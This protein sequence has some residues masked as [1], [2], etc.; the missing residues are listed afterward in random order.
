MLSF[1]NHLINQC[2]IHTTTIDEKAMQNNNNI[3]NTNN[4]DDIYPIQYVAKQLK[5]S[6]LES[7]QLLSQRV[8]Q[9]IN[10]NDAISN[11]NN[12]AISNN[13][14]DPDIDPS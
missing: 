13:N 12:D 14:N 10:N 8:L 11:N 2:V 4:D 6:Y 5:I 9:H 3:P 1:L 7:E